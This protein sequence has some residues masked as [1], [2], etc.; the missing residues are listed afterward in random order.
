LKLH[1]QSLS[2]QLEA[3]LVKFSFL[4]STGL[5]TWLIDYS[6]RSTLETE[7]VS[8]PMCA[9]FSEA[10][11]K[12]GLTPLKH[13]ECLDLRNLFQGETYKLY[14]DALRRSMVAGLRALR[15]EEGND[16]YRAQGR[17]DEIEIIYRLPQEIEYLISKYEE[18][19]E[20]ETELE[21]L[22]KG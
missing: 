5:K 12:Q 14:Q 9:R 10:V 20:R 21:R 7:S 22:R 17:M 19:D 18:V 13:A 6:F 3:P 11:L 2:N 8:C 1:P 16:L 15:G 4:S